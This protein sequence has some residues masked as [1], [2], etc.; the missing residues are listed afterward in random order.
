MKENSTVDFS[1]NIVQFIDM[2]TLE[3]ERREAHRVLE[4]KTKEENRRQKEM[5]N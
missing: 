1:L 2:C 4:N 3:K 5:E